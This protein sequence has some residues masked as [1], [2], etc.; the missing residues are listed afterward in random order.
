MIA[1]NVFHAFADTDLETKWSAELTV[2]DSWLKGSV[3]IGGIGERALLNWFGAAEVRIAML[4]FGLTGIVPTHVARELTIGRF[5]TDFTW[6]TIDPDARPLVGLIELENAE[7]NTLFEKKARAIP[8]IGSRFLGGFGQL[9]DWCAFGSAD[10]QIDP[11]IS[12]V[13]GAHP[14]SGET[15]YRFDL[16]AGL[17]A[18]AADPLSRSRLS[19]WNQNILVGR[20]TQTVT[21]TRLCEDVQQRLKV[22]A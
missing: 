6:A 11:N 19:W 14:R 7:S 21:F 13:I 5:R 9:V 16:V 20:G 10:A 15:E 17:D 18:F 22:F 4:A 3:A 12:A 8:H 1:A 2:L